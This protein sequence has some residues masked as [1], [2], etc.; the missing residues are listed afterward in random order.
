MTGGGHGRDALAAFLDR[1]YRQVW[2][3]HQTT[4]ERVFIDWGEATPEMRAYTRAHLCCPVPGCDTLISARGR[5][6]RDHFF[7]LGK[8]GHGEGEGEWHLQAKA[9]LTEWA[10]SQEGVV[11]QEEESVSIPSTGSLR[12]ADVMATWPSTGTKVAIEVEY[13]DYKPEQWADKQADYDTVGVGCT[14]VF[15]HLP[16]YLRQP[17]KPKGFPEDETWDRLQWVELTEAVARAG[18]PIVFINPVERAVVTAVQ[19]QRSLEQAERDRDWW[20]YADRVG[21]RLAHPDSHME[22]V[23]ELDPLDECTLDPERGLITPTMRRVEIERARIAD[24][25]SAAQAAAAVE[26]KRQR[27]AAEKRRAQQQAD[28]DERRRRA[29][30]SEEEREAARAY[31]EQMRAQHARDWENHPLRARIIANRG[32]IPDF[33]ACELPGDRAIYAHPAHWHSQ[34]FT[35]LVLGTGEASRVGATAEFTDVLRMLRT[36]RIQLPRDARR[37]FAAIRDFLYHLRDHGYLSIDDDGGI[38]H[39]SSVTV[40]AD[41]NTPKPAPPRREWPVQRPQPASPP[42][43]P[44]PAPPTPGR[45]P[46]TREQRWENAMVRGTITGLFPGGIPGFLADDPTPDT[47]STI[48]ALPVHWHAYLYL[49]Y[50]ARHPKGHAFNLRDACNT[51]VE[52]RLADEVSEQVQVVVAAYLRHLSQQHLLLAPETDTLDGTYYVA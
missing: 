14:W 4:G 49:K 24:L 31:G 27:E 38:K 3:V 11:A 1:Q 32:E 47:S 34:L 45:T 6:K 29:A 12:R 23:L 16:R 2:A 50:I 19:H 13:K 18:R 25:A 37:S 43:Q 15:G 26:A 22:P 44:V 41:L 48:D 35:D 33:L 28:E 39:I 17:R 36:A 30:R 10:N 20:R 40:I 46:D 7:H 9:L 52:H 51:V 5:T 8:P 21:V 42:P